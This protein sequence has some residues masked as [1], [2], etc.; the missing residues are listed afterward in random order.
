MIGIAGCIFWI[1]FAVFKFAVA[2]VGRTELPIAALFLLITVVIAPILVFV[3][4]QFAKKYWNRF[5]EVLA[6]AK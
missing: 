5:R 1:A 3:Q 2:L 4:L 6:L